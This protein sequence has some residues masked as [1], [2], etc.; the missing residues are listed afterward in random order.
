M[1]SASGTGRR[2]FRLH[3]WADRLFQYNFDTVYRPGNQNQVAD[4]LSRTTNL[5]PSSSPSEKPV[6]LLTTP[7]DRLI[8]LEE[9]QKASASDPLLLQVCDYIVNG[10]PGK[11]HD[12]L[13]ESFSR[14]RDELTVCNDSCVARGDRAVIP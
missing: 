12:P 10:W 9:L 13:F 5:S 14:I 2:P 4:C 11:L 7:F 8:T 6:Q 3:R 1:L